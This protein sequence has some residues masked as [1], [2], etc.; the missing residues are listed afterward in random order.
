M[1]L[2]RVNIETDTP[3][4]VGSDAG[5]GTTLRRHLA[6]APSGPII[7][8]L[9]GMTFSPSAPQHCP[10]RHILSLDPVLKAKHVVSWPRHLGFGRDNAD[11]GLCIAV[12]WEARSGFRAAYR[13]AESAG[14]G[15]AKLVTAIHALA[16]GR[17]VNVVAHSLG[18]RVF[19]NALPHSPDVFGRA[20]LMAAAELR[21]VAAML[22][23]CPAGRAAE[24]INVTSR[25]NDIFD[26]LVERG[27]RPFGF[28]SRALG[29]GLDR[30][31]PR[32]LDLQIDCERT[33]DGLERLGFRIARPVRRICHRSGYLRPGIFPLYAALLRTPHALPL[34]VVRNAIPPVPSPRWSR[35]FQRPTA[36]PP[37]PSL[38]KA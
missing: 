10:H 32:W 37:L 22:A 7:I 36:L 8:L 31:D 19:L 3:V 25:E 30:Q 9:H 1:P 24:I 11:E 12:G 16:P 34:N 29:M 35:L 20:I 13:A 38:R 5:L 15:V 21:E 33:R 6:K 2:M 14:H 4:P 18:A 17:D 27:L 28:G 26:L 23:D